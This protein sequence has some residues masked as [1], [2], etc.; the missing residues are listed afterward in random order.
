MSS[1]IKAALE[2]VNFKPYNE[3][4]IVIGKNDEG[5]YVRLKTPQ[6]QKKEPIDWCFIGALLL[7]VFTVL[8]SVVGR[9]KE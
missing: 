7:I 8:C 9:A 3:L 5:I 1:K 2:R 6:V 4:S